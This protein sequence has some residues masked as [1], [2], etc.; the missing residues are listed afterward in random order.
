MNDESSCLDFRSYL[1]SY[2]TCDVFEF[3]CFFLFMFAQFEHV[4]MESGKVHHLHLT[5][6]RGAL[7]YAQGTLNKTQHLVHS[8]AK[9][10]TVE[11]AMGFS[12]FGDI[13]YRNLFLLH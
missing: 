3:E 9:V 13:L 2:S 7:T 10:F 6:L 12:Y 4:T 5:S 8:I 11:T 1:K